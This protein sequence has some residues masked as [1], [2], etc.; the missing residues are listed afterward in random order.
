[1][2]FYSH[3]DKKLK[4]HLMEVRENGR[5]FLKG[6]YGEEI[7]VLSLC[8]DFGKYTEYFQRYLKEDGKKDIYSN[9]GFISALCG[10]FVALKKWGQDS[11]L[12]LIIYNS[13]LHHH[14]SITD[15]KTNLPKSI[16]GLSDADGSLN[17]KVKVFHKQIENMK[18]N[19]EFIVNDYEEFNYDRYVE[20]F[21]R[22]PEEDKILI[23]LDKIKYRLERLKEEERVKLY[24]LH[25]LLY[26]ALISGDKFSAS[27][28][29]L[30]E[31]KDVAFETLD[32]ARRNAIKCRNRDNLFEIRSEIFNSIQ[33][34]LLSNYDKK[35]IFTIT[36]PTGTGKTYSGFFAALKL[37]ELLNMEGKIV[38]ALPFTSIINQNYD[39][40][41]NLFD[42]SYKDFCKNESAYL[43]KHHSLANVDYKSED[44]DTNTLQAEMLMENWSST[45][46]VTTFVQLLETLISNRNKMLKKFSAFRNSIIL[47][48]EIQAI[49]IKYYGLV[50]FIIEEACKNLKCKVIMMT[51]TK[52][53]LLSDSVELLKEYEGY[54]KC[55]HRTYLQYHSGKVTVEEFCDDFIEE[56]EEKSYLIIC[57]TIK[58]SLDIFQKLYGLKRRIFY[59]S[60]NL[61][62]KDRTRVINEVI[63]SLEKKEKPILIS[64][65]VVEAGV[66][67][68]FDIIIRDLAPLP[69]IIQGAGRGNRNG[70]SLR[71]KVKIVSMI[72]ERNQL[73]G[74]NIYGKSSINITKDILAEKLSI[75]E[76]DYL[77]II[78]DYF[79]RVKESINMDISKKFINSISN[80][81]YSEGE[82]QYSI[83]DFSLID[84]KNGY[85]DVFIMKDYN[86]ENTFKKFQDALNNKN[87]D[88]KSEQ[89]IKLKSALNDY[90]L[91][92]PIKYISKF[93]K[94]SVSNMYFMPIEGV[95]DY[96]DKNTGLKRTEDEEYMIF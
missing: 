13:I 24:F 68:D 89:L 91:S 96:Y 36:A 46:I 6:Q 42:N 37:R 84:E 48:D 79:K 80:L 87:I 7:E 39:V 86:G 67:M 82:P 54:F 60:T 45:V 85:V 27:N 44:Y 28:T 14:G 62:P 26:S 92:I 63:Q 71:A 40:I 16:R 31:T 18:E 70:K 52:P 77:Y 88:E 74:I 4:V 73:F 61:I 3:P 10:A 56:L 30:I 8:H 55:F 49:D 21:I 72:N 20:E 43:M 57:N 47:L 53:L 78:E 51:A 95:E 41:V 15:F 5:Q 38:Y 66:D 9:H 75:K 32:Q 34:S 59:L 2:D 25:N 83:C 64:T 17:V 65:Q 81:N 22:E 94:D 58:Q 12:P 35:S 23:K 1:M 19:L 29:P 76:E 69:S 93:A 33:A 90:T 50:D 11:Y